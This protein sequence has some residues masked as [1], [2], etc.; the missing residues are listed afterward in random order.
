MRAVSE[1][2]TNGL[3][4]ILDGAD[5][6]NAVDSMKRRKESLEND[7]SELVIEKS[8]AFEDTDLP[9]IVASL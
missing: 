9:E 2:V 6:H 1:C 4:E 5:R 8:I 7:K 3:K